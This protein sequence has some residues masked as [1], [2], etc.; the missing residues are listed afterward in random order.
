MRNSKFQMYVTHCSVCSRT[1]VGCCA[2][3]DAHMVCAWELYDK[4][5]IVK[6]MEKH[7]TRRTEN[8]VHRHFAILHHVT[9]MRCKS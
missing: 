5:K 2:Q 7:R 9:Y 4:S 1:R 6:T 3:V 8:D